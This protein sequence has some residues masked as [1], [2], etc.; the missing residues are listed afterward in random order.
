MSKYSETIGSFLRTGAY[1]LEADYIFHSEEELK[2]FYADSEILHEGLFKVVQNEAFQSLYWVYNN[3][4]TLEFRKLIDF[5]SI[6]SLFEGL[7]QLKK[8]LEKESKSREEEGN[9]LIGKIND[10]E[11]SLDTLR[12][13]IPIL[14]KELHDDIVGTP[15]KLDTLESL[16]TALLALTQLTKNREDNL[17][18]ELDQTQIGVGLSG[19]GSY[20]ADK[21]TYY[22]QDATSVMNALKTLDSAIH[23]INYL[24]EDT[25]SISLNPLVDEDNR[26][27]TIS[28]DVKLSENSDIIINSD[29]LY[30][31]VEQEFKN[32]ILTLKVN[33]E[34]RSEYNI[35]L[36][37]LVQ[38][39]YYDPTIEALVILFKLHDGTTQRAEI[40]AE[41]LI[42]EW[43]FKNTDA[44][45]TLT[46]VRVIDGPDE[47]SAEINLSEEEGNTIVKKDDGLYVEADPRLDAIYEG[48]KTLVTPTV[49]SQWTIKNQ[50]GETVTLSGVSLTNN[51]ITIEK[52]YKVDYS[53]SFKWTHNSA[54]KDP[55]SV[56]GNYGTTLPSNNVL[57]NPVSYQNVSTTTTYTVTL[58]APKRGLMVSGT[59]VLPAAGNDTSAATAK[60]T[61]QDRRFYGT[62]T[63]SNI[64][65]LGTSNLTA[66]RT[67][68][69][70]NIT[71]STSQYY[72]Y[73]Y[74]KSLGVLTAIIQN[75]AQPIIDAFNRTEVSVVNNAG[76]SVDYY[77]YT[78][79]NV[80]AFTNA[81]IE[82]K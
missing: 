47:V 76:L 78:S 1:P 25:D 33:G 5:D 4:E 72:C 35:G 7:E 68:T 66:S 79:K 82:F 26:T 80:G 19:D 22:L 70:N 30:H 59:K 29:G 58:S 20:N 3:G 14:L 65:S 74:P 31:K 39:S 15:I 41:K 71:T 13:E 6:D 37:A 49:S 48:D 17:Q 38:E 57:S 77:V 56:S 36:D 54:Y 9:T 18:S 61:F 51:S 23:K 16:E 69:V 12:K 32:G 67:L 11:K 10:L 60:V 42:T 62:S 64:T 52:G 21:E 44:A 53:G 24:F 8:D 27:T 28:A 81:T 45:I 2:Q 46:R 55:T 34:V 40:P 43:E 50:D 63:D 73:A 75:G